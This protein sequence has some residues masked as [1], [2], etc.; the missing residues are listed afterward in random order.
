MA[1]RNGKKCKK[2]FT[3]AGK[4]RKTKCHT[5]LTKKGLCPKRRGRSR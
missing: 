4:C 3:R 1:K 2:G 5:R